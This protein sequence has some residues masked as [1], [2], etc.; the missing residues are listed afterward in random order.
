MPRVGIIT[1]TDREAAC[2]DVIPARERPPVVFTGGGASRTEMGARALLGEGCMAIASVGTAGGLAGGLA[3]GSLILPERVIGGAESFGVDAG[4]RAALVAL[5][6]RGG[7]TVAA[8]DMAHSESVL[9]TVA[10][11]QALQAATG[12][13]AV[14]MESLPAARVAAQAGVPFVV[15]RVVVDEAGRALPRV[16]SAAMIDDGRIRVDRLLGALAARPWEIVALVRLGRASTRAF[17]MLRRVAALAGPG[18]GL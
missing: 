3:A 6:E 9:H 14:D 2:L 13:V 8:G 12:A 1:G 15:V 17:R 5:A 11:K 18:L 16:A 10:D 4:W 7:L